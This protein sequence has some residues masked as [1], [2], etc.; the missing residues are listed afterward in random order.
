MLRDIGDCGTFDAHRD[1]VPADDSSRRVL[2]A[3]VGI[4]SVEREVDASDEGEAIV[5]HDGLLVMAV[6]E[7][8]AGVELAVD[9]VSQVE[10]L[11]HLP[12]LSSGRAEDRDRSAAP[13]Q[14]AHV[15]PL[16]QL[17]KQV[18]HDRGI[19]AAREL[20]LRREEAAGEMDVRL[21]SRQLLCDLRQERGSVDE[22][23]HGVSLPNRCTPASPPGSVGCE[24]V[25]PSDLAQASGVMRADGAIDRAAEGMA[26]CFSDLSLDAASGSCRLRE[27]GPVGHAA[28]APPVPPGSV[29]ILTVQSYDRRF[30]SVIR[31]DVG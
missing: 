19:V 2:L 29:W 28:R 26:R 4:P 14:H 11:D 6:H 20:E 13:D 8:N 1:V 3:V 30:G 12:N 23:F 9:P 31:S 24:R 5:D 27:R 7:A 22:N 15:D 17:G 25:L 21:R 10:P 18:S 16:G